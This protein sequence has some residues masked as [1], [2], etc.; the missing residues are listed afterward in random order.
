MLTRN[1]QEKW[2]LAQIALNVAKEGS[3]P[4]DT[5]AVNWESNECRS[6]STGLKRLLQFRIATAVLLK[7]LSGHSLELSW[8]RAC[9]VWTAILN[10]HLCSI[11]NGI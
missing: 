3:A 6:A 8:K 11:S 5:S 4:F 2:R 1:I 9:C 10:A 7:L